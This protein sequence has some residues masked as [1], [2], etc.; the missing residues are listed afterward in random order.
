M[1]KN[2][3]KEGIKQ[4]EE[5]TIKLFTHNESTVGTTVNVFGEDVKLMLCQQ[6]SIY[7]ES[8]PSMP[9]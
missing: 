2:I 9:W 4:L 1:S 7:Y 6:S 5:N 3:K 8:T